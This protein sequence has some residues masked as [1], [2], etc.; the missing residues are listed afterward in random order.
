MR[1]YIVEVDGETVACETL[2]RAAHAEGVFYAGESGDYTVTAVDVDVT[3]D[4]IRRLLGN[5]GGYAGSTQQVWP[6]SEA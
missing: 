1:F 6:R 2:L 4:N 5:L 3:A